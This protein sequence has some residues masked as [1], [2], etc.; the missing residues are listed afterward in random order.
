MKLWNK[1]YT[2][3]NAVDQ[4]TVGNDR[5]LDMEIA[6]ADLIASKAHA[7]MLGSIGILDQVETMSIGKELDRLLSE[8]EEGRFAIDEEFEDVH[9]KIEF[10]LVKALGDTGKK[11]HTGRSRNDQVLVAL[12]LYL[13]NQLQ[14]YIGSTTKLFNRLLDLSDQH[15]EVLIPG[16]THMQVAMPSSIGLW[17]GGY[18]ELLIDDIHFLK[19]AER[20]ADQN[21]LGSGAGY[22]SSIPLDRQM[23]SDEIG[24][25]YP[26][27]NSA[28]AMM[29]RGKL[30]K[31]VSYAMASLAGTL[32]RLA[33]DITFYINENH[34]FIS[35]PEELTTGSSIMPHKK[36][37]DVFELV[38]AKCNKIQNLPNELTLITNNLPSGYHRDYQILKDSL[39]PAITMLHDCLEITDFMLSH[40]EV[41]PSV[42]S[43]AAYDLLFSVEMVNRLVYE[44]MPFREAYQKVG[45][46]IESGSFKPDRNLDHSHM[47]SIGNLSNDYIR[48][49]FSA[50]LK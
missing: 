22:G 12:H 18:A 8:L 26:K 45:A 2:I 1:G 40:L 3:E 37:P 35:F 24:F 14:E 50:A 39:F 15:K 10:E 31:S 27:I 4:F 41:L 33:M 23:T 20:V 36:N 7:K 42:L 6:E 29:S 13:K 11:I 17:L 48:Q 46:D 49:K 25:D 32:S 28:A 19:A 5:V 44:G 30:E 34:R 47:G 43:D 21:P 16:Y 38:R 9:S